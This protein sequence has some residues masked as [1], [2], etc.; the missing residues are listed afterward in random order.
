MGQIGGREKGVGE[1]P[2]D[3]RW[4]NYGEAIA[5]GKKAK[6][7]RA[8][9]AWLDSFTIGGDGSARDRTSVEGQV[10][11]SSFE[12][13][14]RR[15]RCFLFGIPESELRQ[16]EELAREKSGGEAQIFRK[17]ISRKKALEVLAQ[18]GRLQKSDYLRCR[19]RYFVDGAALGSKD[20]IEE[21]FQASKELFHPKRATGPRPLRGIET[22]PKPNRLYNLRQLGKDALK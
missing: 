6:L 19:V 18:G 20:F 22:V 9:V 14:H 12:E 11:P 10:S 13:S 8:A 15:C 5:G 7:A 17:R 2:R 3:Y 16:K 1:D 21:V 4:C